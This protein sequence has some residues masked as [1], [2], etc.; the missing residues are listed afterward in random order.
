MLVPIGLA[1]AGVGFFAVYMAARSRVP[2]AR[3]FDYNVPVTKG[4]AYVANITIPKAFLPRASA[5]QVPLIVASATKWAK[6]KNIPVAEVLAT[7]QVESNGN[8][9]AWAKNDKEDSRGLMQVN[10]NAWASTLKRFGMTVEDLWD[11]DKNIQVGVEIYANY[12]QKVVDAIV[13][14]GKAQPEPIDVITRQYYRGPATV[15]K[16][17]ATG[18]N[19]AHVFANSDAAAGRGN[20]VNNWKMAMNTANSVVSTIG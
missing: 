2:A 18:K 1:V 3:T 12:R 17:I 10:V 20:S 14:S 19:A 8:P 16:A 15:L 4:G 6:A 13:K 9:R 11:I 7:I 5:A